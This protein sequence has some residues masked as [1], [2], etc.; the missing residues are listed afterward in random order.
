MLW[1]GRGVGGYPEF[2]AGHDRFNS[3]GGRNAREA[4]EVARRPLLKTR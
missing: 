1:P 2:S 3:A 4:E